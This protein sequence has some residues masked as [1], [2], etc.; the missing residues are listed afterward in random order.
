MKRIL[1]LLTI[2]VLSCGCAGPLV[3]DDDGAIVMIPHKIGSDGHIIVRAMIN[4]R[5]P[6]KFALDTGA[7]ISVIFEPTRKDAGLDLLPDVRVLIHGMVG[8]GE[9][10]LTTIADFKIGSESWTNARM[11]SLPEDS[12]VSSEFDGILGV[13]F[14]RRYAVGVSAEDQVVRLY[15]PLLV[16][17]RSYHGWTSVPMRQL[18]IGQGDTTAY[19]I[20]LNIN[21]VTIPALLDLGASFNMMN[22]RAARAIRVKPI[23]A[24]STDTLSGAVET[25]PV[26]AR[27]EVDELKIKDLRWRNRTF[28]IADFPVFEVLNLDNR[29]VA[30]VGPD[31]FNERDYVI[32]FV[33]NRMLIKTSK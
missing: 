16:R 7:S 28:L 20:N 24:H 32:D 31:L 29:P 6:F 15:P 5:G 9:F 23:K 4:D 14:L 33:R 10:P 22:W 21:G 2:S 19:A 25:E 12:P 17:E 13:D 27:L 3:L 11:A 30:I 1:A 8:S 18:Q 26:V